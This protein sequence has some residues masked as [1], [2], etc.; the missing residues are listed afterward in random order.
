MHGSNSVF[1]RGCI[2]ATYRNGITVYIYNGFR[3]GCRVGLL[4]ENNQK[5]EDMKDNEFKCE[6]CGEV[7]EKAWTDEEAMKECEDDF[8][9]EMANSEDNAIVCD[10]CYQKMLPSEHLQQLAI[11]QQE[12][13]NNLL[14]EAIKKTKI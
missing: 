2:F 14:D 1:I 12:F 3:H 5:D 8:G 9:V 6:M 10:D 7:Y 4:S 11:A 13:F